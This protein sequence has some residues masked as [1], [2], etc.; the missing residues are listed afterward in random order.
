VA[1]TEESHGIEENVTELSLVLCLLLSVRECGG[2]AAVF[3]LYHR[4]D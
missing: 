2:G 1:A 3:S 4:I